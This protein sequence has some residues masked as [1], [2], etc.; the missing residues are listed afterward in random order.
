MHASIRRRTRSHEEDADEGP[1]VLTKKEIRTKRAFL[2]ILNEL[3]VSPF[4]LNGGLGCLS[5]L[6]QFNNL[7]K[8][9]NRLHGHNS[10]AAH[11]HQGDYSCDAAIRYLSQVEDSARTDDDFVTDVRFGGGDGISRRDRAHNSPE[12]ILKSKKEILKEASSA[13]DA[14]RSRRAR[15]RWRYALEKV[16]TGGLSAESLVGL[17]ESVVQIWKWRANALK[18]SQ[19]S[20]MPSLLIRGWRPTL[21]FF[22]TNRETD[23]KLDKKTFLLHQ[24]YNK[25]NGTRFLWA[26]PF[27]LFLQDIPE[28]VTEDEIH[29]TFLSLLNGTGYRGGAKLVV[30]PLQASANSTWKA[31]VHFERKQFFDL[32]RKEL[33]SE[34]GIKLKCKYPP[35]FVRENIKV[36]EEKL[37]E[38]MAANTVHPCWTTSAKVNE[39]REELKFAQLGLCIQQQQPKQPILRGNVVCEKAFAAS[40]WL[41][42]PKT[43]NLLFSTTEKIVGD[44]TELVAQKR[45]EVGRL[46]VEVSRLEKRIKNQ[47]SGRLRSL[48]TFE[49][50]QKLKEGQHDEDISCPICLEDL[51]Q[52]DGSEGKIA[53]TRCGHM[54]CFECMQ[55][56]LAQD[57]GIARAC[58]ECRKPIKTGE[59]IRVDPA[60]VNEDDEQNLKRQTEA[61]SLIRQA[62]EMLKTNHGKLEPRFWHALY[63]S[64]DLPPQAA[65]S[66]SM[67]CTAIPGHFL[68]HLRHSTGLHLNAGRNHGPSCDSKLPSKIRALLEDIPKDELSVVFA[69]SKTVVCHMMAVL[70]RKGYGCRGLFAGQT[71]K[72]SE[73]A[74]SEWQSNFPQVL[75]LVVQAGRAACGLTLTA[76]RKMFLLEPFRSHEEEKQAYA[77]LHRYGQR[78]AVTCKIYYTP[79]SVESRLLEWRR[80]ATNHAAD[81][82]SS[83]YSE[84]RDIPPEEEED[85]D[86]SSEEAGDSSASYD[87]DD[88]DS[89]S[90]DEQN[91]INFLLGL[92]REI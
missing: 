30:Y 36:A 5:Q 23:Q 2:R 47:V 79:V 84:L 88:D 68:A 28:Q 63:W 49:K 18:V 44:S 9:Y 26:H 39:A 65:L 46:K 35:S 71:E 12:I 4:L 87:D 60:L 91:Q 32:A 15:A 75:V 83:V 14:A 7:N 66:R 40:L 78:H 50:L 86:S 19:D 21:K 81:L 43:A 17:K 80:R 62:A 69:S 74:V 34:G 64:V 53:L 51:G 55:K 41:P 13:L 8:D 27:A 38:A 76:A 45:G 42:A 61:K 1:E 22:G 56:W 3:C 10:Q 73:V 33:K 24:L 89:E 82:P 90:D 92:D 52:S 48:N 77:R 58:V 20:E 57:Q 59:V 29:Q 67:S 54:S 37:E 70:E 6:G 11:T 31:F 85:S 25:I 72:D 16:T